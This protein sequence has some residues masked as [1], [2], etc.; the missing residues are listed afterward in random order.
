MN[1]TTQT[2]A[3][4]SKV[5]LQFDDSIAEPKEEVR[6]QEEVQKTASSQFDGSSSSRRLDESRDAPNIQASLDD[7]QEIG[8]HHLMPKKKKKKKRKDRNVDDMPV[9]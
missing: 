1:D 5:L 6:R 3:D 4:Q 2:E 7:S 8:S 9:Q